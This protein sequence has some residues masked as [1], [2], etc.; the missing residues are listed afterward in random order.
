[1]GGGAEGKLPQKFSGISTWLLC[2]ISKKT[3]KNAAAV[4]LSS[5]CAILTLCIPTATPVVSGSQPACW[6]ASWHCTSRDRWKACTEATSRK[7]GVFCP[8]PLEGRPLHP[9]PLRQGQKGLQ[10]CPQKEG[11]GEGPQHPAPELQ[12]AGQAPSLPP[13]GPQQQ[14]AWQNWS[15]VASREASHCLPF[16]GAEAAAQ[17]LALWAL[18]MTALGSLDCRARQNRRQLLWTTSPRD[19]HRPAQGA[20]SSRPLSQQE[21]SREPAAGS[22]PH[23]PALPTAPPLLLMDRQ[24]ALL[25]PQEPPGSHWCQA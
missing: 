16:T 15:Q 7:W 19:S 17:P 20:A 1:M 11:E 23:T 18:G 9:S 12:S 6:T 25:E 24:C 13:E 21:R 14:A 3:Q 5:P 2:R 8:C 22:P 4:S 10:E